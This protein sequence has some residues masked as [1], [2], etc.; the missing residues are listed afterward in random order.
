MSIRFSEGLDHTFCNMRLCIISDFTVYVLHVSTSK[1]TD[2]HGIRC[3][4][5]ILCITYY[6]PTWSKV[7]LQGFHVQ[8]RISQDVSNICT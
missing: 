1:N 7:N 3:G 2:N 6:H 4:S 8:V 5:I